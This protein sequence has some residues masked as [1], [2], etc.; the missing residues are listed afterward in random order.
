MRTVFGV[1]KLWG[2]GLALVVTVAAGQTLPI[3]QPVYSLT[4]SAIPSAA[5]G[6]P[7]QYGINLVSAAGIG[8]TVTLPPATGSGQQIDVHVDAAFFVTVW[9]QTGDQINKFGAGIGYALFPRQRLR[10][11]DVKVGHWD[12]TTNLPLF[13]PIYNEMKATSGGQASAAYLGM[14]TN[15]IR[16]AAA[17][18]DAM[19]L[20]VALGSVSPIIIYN[21]TPFR[22]NL[23]PDFGQNI[24]RQA[25]NTPYRLPPGKL[26][27]FHDIG[28]GPDQWIGGV[29]DAGYTLQFQSKGGVFNPASSTTYYVGQ[30]LEATTFPQVQRMRVPRAGHIASVSAT[31][32]NQGPG[33]NEPSSFYVRKNNVQDTLLSSTVK[34]NGVF[35]EVV[36]ADLDIAVD[37]G[38]YIEFKWVSPAWASKPTFVTINGIV[39]IE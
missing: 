36:A 15:V 18:G 7:L 26:A 23:F 13:Y 14:G 33:S 29:L 20:P 10:F 12:F 11:L 5:G 35:G 38:D 31:F 22:L 28:P 17:P 37:A 2:Y 32:I 19:R 4:A 21:S 27:F 3:P 8:D 39:Y 16:S 24:N 25:N 9:P 34:N 6:T 1:V 30:G